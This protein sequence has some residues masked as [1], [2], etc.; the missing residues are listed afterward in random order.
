MEKDEIIY[1][2]SSVAVPVYQIEANLGMPK[3]T[4]QKA[5]KGE[6]DLPKKWELKL[7][8]AYP[9]N[10][11]IKIT[12]GTKPTNIVEPQNPLG[13]ETSN[14]TI[15]TTKM[16]APKEETEIEKLLRENREKFSKQY[17]TK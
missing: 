3:T 10:K 16:E 17:K 4:L 14:F 13:S 1:L 11:E 7:L 12:D 5:I 15:D 2:L 6:R 9:I 8:E